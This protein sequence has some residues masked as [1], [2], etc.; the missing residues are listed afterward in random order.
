M[1]TL[2]GS[3]CVLNSHDEETK[4]MNVQANTNTLSTTLQGS[5]GSKPEALLRACIKLNSL[6]DELRIETRGFASHSI[7]VE[8]SR[9][10]VLAP[11]TTFDA[12][13]HK[14]DMFEELSREHGVEFHPSCSAISIK[15][16]FMGIQGKKAQK[17]ESDLKHDAELL[18][19]MRCIRKEVEDYE[20]EHRHD[21]EEAAIEALDDIKSIL[22][23]TEAE[24]CLYT[25][26]MITN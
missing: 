1:C 24:L 21:A 10:F 11:A 16:D 13:Q 26:G 12:A 19:A 14:Q 23:E 25:A 18:D 2:L 4:A 9:I 17:T 6:D 22:A 20:S 7:V 8:A 5:T 15:R 3:A